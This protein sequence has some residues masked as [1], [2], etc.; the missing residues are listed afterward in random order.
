MTFGSSYGKVKII[1]VRK[2]EIPLSKFGVF[3]SL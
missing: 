3:W 1:R 2:I